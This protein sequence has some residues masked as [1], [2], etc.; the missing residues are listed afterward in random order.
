[1]A[2]YQHKVRTEPGPVAGQSRLIILD[3]L[4]E[5]RCHYC[6]GEANRQVCPSPDGRYH[7]HGLAHLRGGE[8]AAVCDGC[9]DK[10]RQ[11][12]AS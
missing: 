1:M 5:V 8:L 11:E 9:I 4:E 7:W 12:W 2:I 6:G 3:E 10:A